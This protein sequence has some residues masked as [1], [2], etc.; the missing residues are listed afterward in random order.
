MSVAPWPAGEDELIII[1]ATV[2]AVQSCCSDNASSDFCARNRD[3]RQAKLPGGG[4]GWPALRACP[5][6]S[7]SDRGGLS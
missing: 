2:V 6:E 3:Q 5:R 1:E 7:D 4:A